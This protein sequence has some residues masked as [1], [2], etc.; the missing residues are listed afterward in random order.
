MIE[1]AAATAIVVVA[2]V[3]IRLLVRQGVRRATWP[4]G[5][6]GRRLLVLARNTTLAIGAVAIAMIWAAE[7]RV[8]GL[9]LVAVAVAVVIS[10]QDVIR[11]AV[12]AFI[13]AA[14][15][16]FSIGDRLTIGDVRGYVIDHSLAN[17]TLLEI[18]PGHVRTGRTISVPNSL[19][20][21]T[22]ILNETA[23]HRYV[24]HSFVVPVPEDRWREAVASLQEA[25]IEHSRPHADDVRRAME[26]RA[27]R[28]SLP[29][30]AT[31]PLVSA[32]QVPAAA[33]ST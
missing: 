33:P 5:D 6:D 18:G 4:N 10:V 7:L 22:P 14:T 26:D 29:L 32:N 19:L 3:L 23:G 2:V 17:T 13:R 16:Q 30:P 31:E 24:L 27:L 8:I 28:H 1:K 21:S 12:A 11:A 20:L 9:S 15:G 25:A